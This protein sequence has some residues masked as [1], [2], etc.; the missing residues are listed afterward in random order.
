M[1]KNESTPKKSSNNTGGSIKATSL[2][3]KH[4]KIL[5]NLKSLQYNIKDNNII[6]DKDK[7]NKDKIPLIKSSSSNSLL[8][9]IDNSNNQLL[10]SDLE[11]LSN[12]SKLIKSSVLPT[13]LI[14]EQNQDDENEPLIEII[15]NSISTT[16]T[17]TSITTTVTTITPITTTTTNSNNI[18]E[19]SKNLLLPTSLL[20]TNLIKPDDTTDSIQKN[21][22]FK[23][24][25]QQQQSQN[26]QKSPSNSISSSISIL[27]SSIKSNTNNNDNKTNTAIEVPSS[28]LSSPLI[29][30][31][32]RI[33][34]TVALSPS[35]ILTTNN[36]IDNNIIKINNNGNIFDKK[37]LSGKILTNNKNNSNIITT[38]TISNS[39]TSILNKQSNYRDQYQKQQQQRPQHQASLYYYPY[40]YS[41]NILNSSTSSSI[42]DGGI[43]CNTNNNNN[44]VSGGCNNSSISGNLITTS[45]ISSTSSISLT[46]NNSYHQH[47]YNNNS[48]SI[49]SSSSSSNSSN[50]ITGNRGIANSISSNS[51]NIGGNG[52]NHIGYVGNN[53]MGG[54]SKRHY[55]KHT[56]GT[57]ERAGMSF[58]I[59]IAFFAVFGLIILT[60]LFMIDDK[61]RGGM[62]ML[63]HGNLNN[64][65]MD[66]IQPDYDNPKYGDDYDQSFG[67]MPKSKN[68]DEIDP[69]RLK[70]NRLAWNEMLETRLE[71]TLPHYPI[72][73]TPTDGIWKVVNGTRFKFFVYSAYYDRRL[74]HIVRIIGA[75]KTR[76]P[77]KVFCRLWY[78]IRDPLN[79]NRTKHTS[80]TLSAKVKIIR[81]HWNLKY[82]AVFVLCP[83][84]PQDT[85]FAVS[86]V[87]RL[88]APPG[89]ILQ[90]RNTNFDPDFSNRTYNQIPD[91]MAI[92]VKPFHFNYDQ[93][94]YL[95]EYLELNSLLGVSHFTFYNHTIG[96]HATCVLQHYAS[97]DIPQGN[98]TEYDIFDIQALFGIGNNRNSNNNNN[99]NGNNANSGLSGGG[100]SI[101]N[102]NNI[103]NNSILSSSSSSSSVPSTAIPLQTTTISN[104]NKIK[105][106]K[107]L[108]T[109]NY[110]VPTVQILPW[111]LR[112]RSQSEIRTEGLFAALN[113]CLYRNMYRYKYLALIDVDE[114]LM[115]KY[116]DSLNDLLRWLNKKYNIAQVGSYSFQNAFFYLQFADDPRLY[117]TTSKNSALRGALVTQRKTR[118]RL[119]LHPQKQRSKYIVN[120][121]AVVEAGNHFVWDF[122]PGKKT[123]NVPADAGIL[124]HY[125]V[126]EFGGDDCVKVPS[127]LDRTAIKYTNRLIERVEKVYNYL[128]RPC[129]LDNL[130]PAPT[131]PPPT[132]RK[133]LQIRNYNG[134]SNNNNN[135]NNINSNNDINNNNNDNKNNINQNSVK[136]IDVKKAVGNNYFLINKNKDVT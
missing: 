132:R 64:R 19:N 126:C 74:T 44:G 118:R 109:T 112:M 79:S 100:L 85:P 93:A 34:T 61:N 77:E 91:K 133:V 33:A 27:S 108:K 69:L 95:M 103:N 104:N 26:K 54:N 130:P 37:S 7:N 12:K 48:S 129:N 25:F 88:R 66:S 78:T 98:L 4:N 116:N 5:T 119:R 105:K 76:R 42:S 67:F 16:N 58:L 71:Q 83:I 32:S 36:D 35:S 51:N 59:V 62:V 17:T 101:R 24:R 114:F 121:E 135:H 113:D 70:T 136:L 75:T 41:R 13:L 9:E 89:N 56:W 22:Q 94:L 14:K 134:T 72:G 87:S 38:T 29:P 120:P 52:N 110:A 60:E 23:Q 39:T 8:L 43:I 40:T 96:P 46:S 106:M 6:K 111:D 18:L 57:R 117:E 123:F 30:I 86:V 82:S 65:M 11:P 63:R 122:I 97:G 115:P 55:R 92:C 90:L 68:P 45:S 47:L 99:N 49:S 73:E 2:T 28:I 31:K 131:K 125:R 3:Y 15:K 124:H 84:P 21:Q 107:I 53:I 20:S 102:S 80:A 81:E 1:Q 10:S 127:I 50:S 128:K